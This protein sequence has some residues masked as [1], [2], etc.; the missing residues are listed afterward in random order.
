MKCKFLLN[1]FQNK[2]VDKFSD[3]KKEYGI[4][5]PIVLAIFR[6]IQYLPPQCFIGNRTD[7]KL[8]NE[9]I[10]GEARVQLAKKRA[11][12]IDLS[13]LFF[14]ILELSYPFLSLNYKL[15]DT[16]LLIIFIARLIDII[17]IN[18]NLILFDHIRIPENRIAK[19]SRSVIL[20]IVNYIEI[21]LIFGFIYWHFNL[22]FNKVVDIY[23]AYYFSGITQL[24]IGYGDIFPKDWMR[25]VVLIQG[26]I[27]TIF[28][29]LVLA[30]II[31]LIP[32]LK[33]IEDKN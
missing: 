1:K 19:Y 28:S 29:F 30:K 21:V 10:Q 3:L 2:I 15:L 24:T 16:I 9:H 7:F 5:T 12:K 31:S 27:S 23:D 33:G 4:I 11:I 6:I 26:F 8:K 32:D 20:L 14:F 22:H 18:V 17:Q 25:L 13:I